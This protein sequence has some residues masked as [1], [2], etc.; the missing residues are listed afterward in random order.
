MNKRTF[1]RVNINVRITINLND[2]IFDGMLENISMGG[3]YAY[4]DSL[5]SIKNNDIA[6]ITIPFPLDSDKDYIVVNGMVTRITE[7]GVAFRFL[8]T[9]MDTLRKLFFLVYHSNI[10]I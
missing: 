1:Y 2:K 9:D 7:K 10:D 4:T 5:A 6:F 3:L 8:E